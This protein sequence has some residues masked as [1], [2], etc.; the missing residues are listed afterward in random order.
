MHIE[1]PGA[2]LTVALAELYAYYAENEQMTANLLRDA[3]FSPSVAEATSIMREGLLAV[4]AL[5][6]AGWSEDL[7]ASKRVEAGIGHA[8]SFGT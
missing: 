2:R 6:S 1:K 7:D 8:V 5:L 4:T 3:T